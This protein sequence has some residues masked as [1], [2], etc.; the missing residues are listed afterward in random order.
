MYFHSLSYMTR[1]KFDKFEFC[2]NTGVLFQ[3]SKKYQ[4][5]HKVAT[6]IGFFLSNPNVILSKTELLNA[7]WDHGGEFRENSLTQTIGELRKHLNQSRS[8]CEYIKTIHQKGYQ[9]T[10]PIKEETS[11]KNLV[12]SI[13]TRILIYKNFNFNFNF[14]F[15]ILISIFISLSL[16][17]IVYNVLYSE[18]TPNNNKKLILLPFENLTEEP[19]S[20][21]FELGLSDMF[22]RGLQETHYF[23]VMNMARLFQEISRLSSYPLKN[24]YIS[25]L[26][27]STEYQVAIKVSIK[28]QDDGYLFSYQL[29]EEEQTSDVFFVTVPDLINSVPI[30]IDQISMS[31]YP[32]QKKLKIVENEKNLSAMS[33]Y[34]KGIQALN[35]IGTPLAK[36][37][38]EAAVI[39]E[40]KYVWAHAQLANVDFE[41]ANWNSSLDRINSIKLSKEYKNDKRLKLFVDVLDAQITFRYGSINNAEFLFKRT[42][43]LA[44][45]LKSDTKTVEIYKGL[46]DIYWQRFEFDKFQQY[47]ELAQNRLS[48]SQELVL[49]ADRMFYL[50]SPVNNGLELPENIDLTANQKRLNQAYSFYQQLGNQPMIAKTLFLMAQ[51]YSNTIEARENNLNEAIKLFEQ[52]EDKYNLSLALTY[53]GFFYLQLHQGVKSEEPL[54]K[55]ISIAQSI[56]SHTLNENGRFHLAFSYFDQAINLEGKNKANMLELSKRK[57]DE[58]LTR[59]HVISNRNI[60]SSALIVGGWLYAEL[61]LVEDALN[62][63]LEAKKIFQEAGMKASATY[64]TYSAMSNLLVMNRLNDVIELANSAEPS[65]LTYHYLARAEYELGNY[66]EAVSVFLKI[67]GRFPELWTKEDEER[68]AIYRTADETRIKVVLEQEKA[69]HS[70]YCESEWNFENSYFIVD[71]GLNNLNSG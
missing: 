20:K 62:M 35:T 32:Q 69:A 55:A 24:I 26:L 58:L 31:V 39:N 40:P 2:T 60:R 25:S 5:R 17:F 11:T 29:F 34:A 3:G 51:N 9:W 6:L 37:Y 48:N 68:L 66:L 67:K 57:F 1:I 47:L 61:G 70:V 4:L 21:W 38:F 22:I 65:K 10:C 49:H 46:S 33:D 13:F 71:E 45:E 36:R 43:D 15:K 12:S 14:N 18:E 52:Q 41:L 28:K 42:L 50:G 23:E 54:I 63:Q 56:K 7:L 27:K 64:A 8:G 19:N 16:S 30:L 53:K 59:K 44:S